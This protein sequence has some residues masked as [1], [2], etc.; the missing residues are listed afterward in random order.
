MRA[1]CELSGPWVGFW[2]QG[3]IRGSMGLALK[4][5]KGKISGR[6]SDLV[7]KFHLIGTYTTEGRV[8]MAKTYVWHGVIYNGAWDGQMICGAWRIP[9]EDS[10]EFEIW[11]ESDRYEVAEIESSEVRETVQT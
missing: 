9:G 4:F 6:G 3:S 10:G 7:G 11:P 1:L 2:I 8:F 5:S